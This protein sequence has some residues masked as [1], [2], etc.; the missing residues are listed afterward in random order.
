MTTQKKLRMTPEQ[1]ALTPIRIPMPL[2]YLI[3]LTLILCLWLV[4][5]ALIT[6]G[7]ISTL[8]SLKLSMMAKSAR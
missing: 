4:F 2:R 5:R 6:G 1:R 3:N 8:K 7:V